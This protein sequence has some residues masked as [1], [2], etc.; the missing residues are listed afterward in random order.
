MN[1]AEWITLQCEMFHLLQIKALLCNKVGAS[2]RL[3]SASLR[4]CVEEVK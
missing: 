2:V 3:I 1:D 4:S